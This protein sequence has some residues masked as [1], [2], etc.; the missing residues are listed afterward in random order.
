MHL[1]KLPSLEKSRGNLKIHNFFSSGFYGE[2]EGAGVASFSTIQGSS[3][4]FFPLVKK[5]VFFS[6]II[7]PITSVLRAECVHSILALPMPDSVVSVGVCTC[8]GA[9]CGGA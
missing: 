9:C 2:G 3:L 4:A 6:G 7:L 8:G 1:E 5:V